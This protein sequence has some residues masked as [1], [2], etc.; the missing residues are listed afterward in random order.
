MVYSIGSLDGAEVCELVGLFILSKLQNL[1][2]K[3]G[4][5]RDDA[6]GVCDLRPR[7]AELLKKKLCRALE[8]YG[9]KITVE[10]NV[11]SVNFLDVNLSLS[12]NT[13]KPYMKPN[14]TPLYVH[15]QSN[16]PKGILRNIPL[17]VN[18]RLSCISA[19][20][21]VFKECSQPY[22]EALARS[23]YDFELKFNPPTQNQSKK[24]NRQR[25]ISWFNPPFSVSVKNKI[26]E[27]YN[28]IVQIIDIFD[29]TCSKP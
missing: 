1:N 4:L 17:S 15:K 11:K 27:Q 25:R 2:I 9:L 14:D 29:I 10:A 5:Y 6:L 7:Q 8:E 13:F 22:Q 20:E 16:H 12:T 3:L 18:K 19:N 21:N 28:K 24:R 26:G 23:G